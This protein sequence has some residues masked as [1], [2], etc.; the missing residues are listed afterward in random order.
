MSAGTLSCRDR[1][2]T[3]AGTLG[4]MACNRG[5][6]YPWIENVK[7]PGSG[8]GWGEVGSHILIQRQWY[9]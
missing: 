7:L 9:Y 1:D 6:N 5:L 8:G 4:F 2:V 3:Y